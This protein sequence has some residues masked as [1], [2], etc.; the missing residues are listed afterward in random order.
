VWIVTVEP[1]LVR[2]THTA[3]KQPGPAKSNQP[4]FISH[5]NPRNTDA[6]ESGFSKSVKVFADHKWNPLLLRV[7]KETL[8]R[9]RIRG[10]SI[11]LRLDLSSPFLGVLVV[12][13]FHFLGDIGMALHDVFGHVLHSLV[14]GV[15]EDFVIARTAELLAG[16]RVHVTPRYLGRSKQML[17]A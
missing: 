11:P 8:P 3:L 10:S 5:Q 15:G 7:A 16:E 12:H 1:H 4:R 2:C 6:S 9:S 14:P 17:L 13:L